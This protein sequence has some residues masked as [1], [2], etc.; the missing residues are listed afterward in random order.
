M[1]ASCIK[2]RRLH[3]LISAA[4]PAAECQ[5]QSSQSNS[6]FDIG[7]LGRISHTTAVLTRPDIREAQAN[8]SPCPR[9]AAPEICAM[10][11]EL[12]PNDQRDAGKGSKKSY[13]LLMLFDGFIGAVPINPLI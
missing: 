5:R 12:L 2:P 10:L 6:V 4:N 13:K 11:P 8:R 3:W 9:L 1:Q 7:R